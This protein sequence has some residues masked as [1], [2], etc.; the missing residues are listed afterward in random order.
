MAKFRMPILIILGLALAGLVWL[1]NQPEDKTSSNNPEKTIQG[2]ATNPSQPDK[3]ARKT[4]TGDTGMKDR[5][6]PLGVL[7]RRQLRETVL[8][9]L[10]SP[11]RKPPPAKQVV[12]PNQPQIIKGPNQNEYSLLGVV[13]GD[14]NKAIALLRQTR[15]GRNIRVEQ[16]D[17]V[18]SWQVTK[19]ATSSVTLSQNGTIVNLSL[20]R[21]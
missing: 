17:M 9:P 1:D 5:R 13:L 10:F 18:G 21:K 4:I 20:F 11:T 8:R 3:A 7:Q 6:N 19:I 12:R 15:N 16:G 14:G 2:A